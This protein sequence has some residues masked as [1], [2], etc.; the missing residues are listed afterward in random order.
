MKTRSPPHAEALALA[1]ATLNGLAGPG[2]HRP[3]AW[4]VE[5][6]VLKATGCLAPARMNGRA[7]PA[8]RCCAER[9]P[10]AFRRRGPDV[11]TLCY[12]SAKDG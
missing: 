8:T 11:R 4:T 10:V 12:P 2:A 7:R 5:Q 9:L 1:V 3:P 6:Y